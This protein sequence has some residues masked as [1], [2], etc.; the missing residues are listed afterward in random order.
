MVARLEGRDE[1]LRDEVIVIGAHSD[2]LGGGGKRVFNGADD[3]ASGVA[4][5]LEIAQRF[6]ALPPAERPKRSVVFATFTAEEKGLLGSRHFIPQRE[7]GVR[8]MD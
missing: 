2:H 7:S 4:A 6:G 8:G 3:N 5:A 1:A